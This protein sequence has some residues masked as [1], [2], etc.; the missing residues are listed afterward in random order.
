MMARTLPAIWEGEEENDC[1][2]TYLILLP[3]TPALFVT[4][5]IQTGGHR[6]AATHGRV[7]ET[8]KRAR[9]LISDRKT[10]TQAHLL[11]CHVRVTRSLLFCLSFQR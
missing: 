8:F 10:V 7:F 9:E 1:L 4:S 5:L 6:T 11:A 3:H 2:V